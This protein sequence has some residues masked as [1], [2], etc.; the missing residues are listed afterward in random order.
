MSYVAWKLS[1]L[2][3]YKV[4]GTGTIAETAKFRDLLAHR[5]GISPKSVRADIIGQ[6]GRNSS[7][8]LF[9]ISHYSTCHNRQ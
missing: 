5:L 8:F 9:I 3:P 1:G 7:K 4:I 2:P 6:Q